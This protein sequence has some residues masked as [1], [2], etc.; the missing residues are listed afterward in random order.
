MTHTLTSDLPE[1]LLYPAIT[2]FQLQMSDSIIFFE[3]E[4]RKKVM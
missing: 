3:E 2:S 4:I 1:A